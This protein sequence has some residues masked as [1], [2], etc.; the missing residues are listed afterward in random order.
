MPQNDKTQTPVSRSWGL[1][2]MSHFMFVTNFLTL[3]AMGVLGAWSKGL[4]TEMFEEFD[5]EL[6][7]MTQLFIS[8]PQEVYLFVF[9]G[10]AILLAV[11]EFVI[12]NRV[13][14]VFIELFMFV[15][16]TGTL[17]CYLIAMVK[18]M[19]GIISQAGSPA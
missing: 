13:V 17:A 11:K 10:L 7:G 19:F 16:I 1:R 3:V 2:L 14:T 9:V 8:V 5:M 4:F 12:K 18:P 6:P 15:F